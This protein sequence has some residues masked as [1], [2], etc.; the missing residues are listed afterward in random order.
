MEN[1]NL[2]PNL[3]KGDR[4]V[5]LKMMFDEKNFEKGMF[6]GLKGT[7]TNIAKSPFPPYYE[8]DVNWDNGRFLKL[9]PDVDVWILERKKRVQESF[10]VESIKKTKEFLKYVRPSDSYFKF[11][12][13]L[14]KSGLVNMLE[15]ADFASFGEDRLKNYILGLGLSLEDYDDLISVAEEA[16]NSLLRGVSK[17][18]V[19]NNNYNYDMI[20][21]KLMKQGFLLYVKDYNTFVEDKFD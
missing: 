19:D 16:R 5:L 13:E 7:V 14:Q 15:S 8:Y 10:D 3:K 6:S 17:Y 18:S 12:K 2:N 20:F 11:M 9:L 21:S 4:V 1:K